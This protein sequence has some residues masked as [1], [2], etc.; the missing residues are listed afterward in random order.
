[1]RLVNKR[2][3]SQ[4]L[5][6]APICA[7]VALILAY[8]VNVPW[9]DDFDPFLDFIDKWT[10]TSHFFQKIGLLFQPNNEH[11][12][13]FGKFLN[14]IYFKIT[15][16]V[17]ITAVHYT[18]AAF[19]LGTCYLLWKV[20]KELKLPPLYFAPVP[21]LLFQL[22]YHLIFLWA[23]CG[24]QHQTV[25]FFV[26]LTCYLLAKNRFGW[27][28][29]AA[30]CS[31]FAMS[32]GIFVWV[33]GLAILLL[34]SDWKR[35]LIWSVSAV[36]AVALYFY[37]MSPQ[38]NEDSFTFF[39]QNPE[40]SLVGFLGNLGGI[41]D[42][43]PDKPIE[44]RLILPVFM[45]ALAVGWIAFWLIGLLAHWFKQTF[46]S[47]T[48]A[49]SA[50]TRITVAL[51]KEPTTTYFL[52]GVLTF[53]L[54]NAAVIGFLRPRF[55]L[56]VVVVSN[57]KLYPALFFALTY[58]TLLVTF[59][60]HIRLATLTRVSTRIAIVIYAI[61]F[62]HY[63]PMLV[64]RRK[65]L[66]VNAHNQENHAFGLG[67]M[68]RS[69]ASHYIDQLMK[70]LVSKG[71]YAYPTQEISFFTDKV[72]QITGPTP[73]DL[74]LLIKQNEEEIEVREENHPYLSGKNDGIFIFMRQEDDIRIYKMEPLTFTGRNPLIH[75]GKGAKCS[76][77]LA[78]LNPGTYEIGALR[79]QNNK[80]DGGIIDEITLRK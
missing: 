15:G 56:F 75:Y 1:M 30:L 25:V 80:I 72:K 6:L 39:M 38:G 36:V 61:S 26:C 24:M 18:A 62:I 58:L 59:K 77:P 54:I 44:Q 8:S 9:F 71:Y 69:P 67:F 53:L 76:V 78:T 73:N 19:T 55:G 13:F 28:L 7:W 4:I 40:L 64:E 12:M 49:S 70:R 11:R 60:E 52:V 47:N 50:F 17:N 5:I 37:G 3:F 48:T 23:I 79:I 51:Q 34:C 35:V 41:F 27:A 32:N 46:R 14:L 2:T 63:F 20:F 65:Y 21:L 43:T 57:Y 45:G 31:N 22:Q 74:K 33:S 16:Q 10:N 68:P 29:A 42:F 66:L